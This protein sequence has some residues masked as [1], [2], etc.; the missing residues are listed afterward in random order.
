MENELWEEKSHYFSVVSNY[1]LFH[2]G[3]DACVHEN[4]GSCE[5]TVHGLKS[6]EFPTLRF[7]DQ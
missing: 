2:K 5:R 3:M 6:L 7:L 1:L 4:D